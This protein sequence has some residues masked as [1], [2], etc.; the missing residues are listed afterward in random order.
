MAVRSSAVKG[1]GRA[2]L[3]VSWSGV[4]RIEPADSSERA[5]TRH[6]ALAACDE[7]IRAR[8]SRGAEGV[9]AL[10]GCIDNEVHILG[11]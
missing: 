6:L 8:A 10:R 4:F 3:V 9:V 1:L 5:V 2:M 7:A 11:Q